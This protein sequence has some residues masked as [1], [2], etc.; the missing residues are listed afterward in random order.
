MD[1]SR[2]QPPSGIKLTSQN[3]DFNKN[4]CLICQKSDSRN[5]QVVTATQTGLASLKRVVEDIAD[6]TMSKRIRLL[7][8]E[9]KPILY[10][11]TSDCYKKYVYHNK[12]DESKTNP[13]LENEASASCVPPTS[14][15]EKDDEENVRNQ[16][17]M[18]RR[19]L[20]SP[21]PKP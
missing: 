3:K 15:N 11:Y 1:K 17:R 14:D 4:R 9:K 8:S 2:G 6:S 13:D 7:E 21:R 18:L 10:H 5:N 16:N 12:E 19:S 20:T